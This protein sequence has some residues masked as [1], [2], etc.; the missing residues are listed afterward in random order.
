MK[1]V[2]SC[3]GGAHSSQVAAAIHLGKLPA[4][5][6]PRPDEL[7][8]LPR[9]DKVSDD[10]RGIIQFVGTDDAGHEV[11]VLGRGPA[12]S[13]VEKAFISG[14]QVAGGDVEQLL[15]VNALSTVNLAMRVGGYLSRRLKWIAVGRPLV[16]LGTRLAFRALVRLVQETKERVQTASSAP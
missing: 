16:I 4:D 13:A 12:A 2:Y 5:R 3:Y 1:I 10:E 15:F 9:F 7:L 14:Y 8:S 11:Y 6:V